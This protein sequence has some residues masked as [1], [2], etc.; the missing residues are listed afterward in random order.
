MIL[1]TILVSLLVTFLSPLIILAEDNNIIFLLRAKSNPYWNT[2]VEGIKDSAKNNGIAPVILQT[3]TDA[4]AEEQ[5]NNCLTAIERKPKLIAITAVN[6]SIGIQCLKKAQSKGI[7]IAVLDSTIPMN[8]IVKAK[9]NLAYNVGSDNFTLGQIAGEFVAKLSEANK[10][11]LILSGA[12]GSDPGKKRVDGFKKSLLDISP[13]SK[14]VAEVS[15]DWERLKAMNITNDILEREPSLSIIYAV[16]DQMALGAVEAVKIHGK[17]KQIK[18][19]GVDGIA[20]ARKAIIEDKMTATVAQLP[21]LIG[22]RSL[23]LAQKALESK[24]ENTTLNEVTATPLL[25]KEVL[26]LNTDPNLKYVR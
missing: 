26:E 4:S 6:S 17:S 12:I 25:T 2:L 13:E 21:Y 15:A 23:E 7:K 19:I 11:I 5:L 18:I 24:S 9:L 14:V 1:R 16:N 20:D 3:E 8:D 22:I 10:K